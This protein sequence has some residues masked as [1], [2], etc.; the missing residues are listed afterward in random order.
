MTLL[1]NPAFLAYAIASVALSANLAFLWAYSGAVRARSKTAVNAEDAATFGAALV[2]A[3][4]PAVARVLR[5]H[6]NAQASIYPFLFLGLV[7]VLAGGG[8]RMAS[9]VFAIFTVAPLPAHLRLSEDAAALAHRVLRGRR[10]LHRGADGRH[11]R[12]RDRRALSTLDEGAS[13]EQ[14]QIRFD[15]GAVY[16]E[17][18]GAWSLIAGDAFL[19]WL[20]P[21]PG[22]RWADVG[23]GNGAFTERLVQ[24][25]APLEVQGIDPSEGQ[26]AYARTRLAGAPVQ[27]R[28]GDA[29]ALPYGD[30]GFD[31]AVMAL[32]IFFVPE[33]AKGV[34]EMARVVKPG[35]SVSAYAWDILGGGFPF[36]ALQQEMAALGSPPVWPPSV[37]A[38]DIDALQSLWA[39]AGLVEIETR[40]IE[41]ERTFADFA[42]FWKIAQGG[43]GIG[44]RVAALKP[45]DVEVLQQRLRAR[46][47]AGGDGPITYAA[48]GP[49]GQGARRR[50][51]RYRVI[52][53]MQTTLRRVAAELLQ[54]AGQAKSPLPA[55]ATNEAK[56]HVLIDWENVQPSEAECRALVPGATD[57][58]LF[59]GP[60]QKNVIQG[61][62]SFGDH[63]TEIRIARSGKNALDFHLSFY[64]GYLAAQSPGARLVVLS[65]DKGYGS[66][67]EHAEVLGFAAS[68]IGVKRVAKARAPARKAAAKKSGRVV[69]RRRREARDGAAAS[70]K[71]GR[72]E[73]AG[74]EEARGC[75]AGCAAADCELAGGDEEDGAGPATAAG[76]ASAGGQATVAG[77]ASGAGQDREAGHRQVARA[78]GGAAAEEPAC[79]PAAQAG[80]S[81]GFRRLTHRQRRRRGRGH[82]VPPRRRRQ[83]RHRREGDGGLP[84]IGSPLA[85]NAPRRRRHDARR[86]QPH[87]RPCRHHRRPGPPHRRHRRPHHCG[88]CLHP[89]WPRPSTHRPQAVPAPASATPARPARARGRAP[90]G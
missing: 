54:L 28:Q 47:N 12:A 22:L 76:K 17:F 55:A 20:A 70:A 2:E 5:A 71:T 56:T 16:E 21:G 1:D 18:M 43:P 89:A 78:A 67:L 32:V 33:P 83:D 75:E 4:P 30:A 31:A 40:V 84:V 80:P 60:N 45:A 61:Y 46:L 7:F 88:R 41:V 49:C 74:C 8:A 86:C 14:P 37:A 42:S 26:L 90:R 36:A 34:A 15:D 39:G 81:I 29:M 73:G 25:C 9:I 19:Q 66:M 79:Q 10:G 11:C 6:E 62:P 51:R 23:C 63:A 27:W 77:E 58:W 50:L 82:A 64:V 53:A 69:R 13:M 87:R 44:A 3:D 38:A 52:A 68:Q 72:R 48:A 85:V 57:V 35:G 24:R 65:N 59:H